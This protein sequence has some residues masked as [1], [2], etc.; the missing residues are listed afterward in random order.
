M[1]KNIFL[2]ILF[3]IFTTTSI[4]AQTLHSKWKCTSK[5]INDCEYNLTFTVTI[6]KGWHIPSIH[7]IKGAEEDVFE[8]E[9]VFKPNADYTLIG[10]LTETKPAT[11]YDETIKLNVLVHY[12]TVTFTQRIKLNSAGKLKINGTYEYQICNNV[13]CIFP[14]KDPFTFDLQGTSV[15]KK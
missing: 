8:T 4:T 5:K 1:T 12:N 11:E 7:K 15:C 6:D 2:A 13:G 14:P 9:I 3:S 10:A